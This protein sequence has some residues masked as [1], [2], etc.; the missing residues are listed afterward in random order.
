MSASLSWG[1]RARPQLQALPESQTSEAE[2]SE[3]RPSLAPSH[4]PH[5]GANRRHESTLAHLRQTRISCSRRFSALLYL[6]RP[7]NL[8]DSSKQRRSPRTKLRPDHGWREMPIEPQSA[9]P[10]GVTS[11]HP[12]LCRHSLRFPTRLNSCCCPRAECLREHQRLAYRFPC[13][14]HSRTQMMIPRPEPLLMNRRTPARWKCSPR[15]RLRLHRPSTS[16]N[17]QWICLG[18]RCLKGPQFRCGKAR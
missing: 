9:L 3:A 4:P 8:S 13:P 18:A 5:K 11:L 17:S 14:L 1:R 12:S 10:A 16:R 2:P 7:L 15:V 6:R